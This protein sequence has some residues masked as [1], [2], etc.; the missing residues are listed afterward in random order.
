MGG[1]VA[2]RA[3]ALMALV[4]P[5]IVLAQTALGD[6]SPG[7]YTLNPAA[8]TVSPGSPPSPGKEEPSGL[9]RKVIVLV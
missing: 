9:Y 4:L 6:V 5:S 8:D 2:V 1:F 7:G 3:V